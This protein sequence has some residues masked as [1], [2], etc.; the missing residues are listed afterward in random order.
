MDVSRAIRSALV[1]WAGM[2]GVI[3]LGRRS[4]ITQMDVINM[5]GSLF[6]EPNSATA[7]VIG[8]F[9]HI[10]MSLWIG[11]AYALGF[12]LTG[13]RPG[14]RTGLMGGAIHWLIASLAVGVAGRKHPKREQL[15]M[16]GFGGLALG[17]RS[18]IGFLAGHLMYGLL[19][20]W[21]YGR[22]DGE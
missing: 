5:E 10:A 6:A 4:N 9:T 16:P 13:L 2:T 19:F 3:F 18:A 1:G 7:E 12:R 11:L 8:F 15:A 17:P 21:Q 20:G 14:R 22:S